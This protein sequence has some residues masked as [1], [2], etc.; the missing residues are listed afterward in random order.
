VDLGGEED[1]VAPAAGQGLADDLL[2]L[3]ARVD[4][5][6]VDEVDPSVE[7]AVD[8]RDGLVVVGVAPGAEHHGSETER[9]HLDSCTSERA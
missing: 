5:G 7:R 3:A 9:A 1:V 4:V 2:G 8:D 6:R